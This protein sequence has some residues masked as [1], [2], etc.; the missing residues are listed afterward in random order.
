MVGAG[1]GGSGRTHMDIDA[2]VSALLA[3]GAVESATQLL[4]RPYTLRGI[5]ARGDQRGRLL[6]FPTANL[7]LDPAQV[8]PANGVY[9]VR[10]GLEGE[11]EPMRPGVAN[12]GVRPTFGSDNARLVEVHL[13]DV[14]R[15][16]YDQPLQVAFIA[17]LREERRFAGI[18]A[19]KA[20]I[21]ADAIQARSMLAQGEN[22]SEPDVQRHD[23]RQ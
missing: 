16:L 7:R 20:Q 1:M 2:Q 15:D 23:A 5:V 19:L 13:L 18:D 11:R 4:G 14:A 12:I 21:T 3:A 17:R 9:A 22:A 6:G 10:V 8:I